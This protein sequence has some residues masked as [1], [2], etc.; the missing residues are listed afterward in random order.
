MKILAPI[1]FSPV[2]V[3]VMETIRG[4]PAIDLAKVYLVHVAEPDPDF[5]GYEAGPDTVRDQV[6]G[7]MRA[8]HRTLGELADALAERGIDATPLQVQGP[9]VETVMN[10]VDKLGIDLL[11][12]GS[13]GH[14]A[15]YDLLVGSISAGIIRASKVPVLVVPAKE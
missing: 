4:L 2:T 13:H 1:D 14:G 5:I 6:A 3:K 12:V 11:V 9:T 10:E 8:D 15:T 7:G